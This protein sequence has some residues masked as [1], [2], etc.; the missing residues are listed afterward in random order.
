MFQKVNILSMMDHG[1]PK[2]ESLA[3]MKELT[4]G[5]EFHVKSSISYIQGLRQLEVFQE[6]EE[7]ELFTW[8]E[9]DKEI[10]TLPHDQSAYIM[11]QHYE[12]QRWRDDDESE[13][14]G[15]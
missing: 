1:F 6:N 3:V 11:E 7:N 8:N 5:N 15:T 14:F 10:L 4:F 2:V 9:L 12:P 13:P